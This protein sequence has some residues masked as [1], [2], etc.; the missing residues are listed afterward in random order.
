MKVTRRRV[1]GASGLCRERM[2]VEVIPAASGEFH[3]R[4]DGKSDRAYPEPER[5]IAAAR[6]ALNQRHNTDRKSSQTDQ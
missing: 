4:D 3:R 1:G 5:V 6:P 2:K